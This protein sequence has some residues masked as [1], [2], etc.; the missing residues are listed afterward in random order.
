MNSAFYDSSD[1]N[2]KIGV[3]R[4]SLIAL[5]GHL[6]ENDSF[7]LVLFNTVATVLQPLKLWKDI[8]QAKLKETILRI[9]A[10]GGTDMS[11]G[12][13]CATKLIEEH[14]PKLGAVS[15]ADTE[16]R[17]IFL[18]DM[19][20]NAGETSSN[21]LFGM[22]S[23]NDAK[24]IYATFVGVGLDFNTDLVEH[25]TTNIRGANYLSVQ[26][27]KEFKK[28]MNEDFDYIV[29]SLVYN[30]RVGLA[31]SGFHIDK[32]YGSPEST[33]TDGDLMKI[34]TLFPSAKEKE[35]QTKGG[36]VLIKLR[37]S[38]SSREVKLK[39]SFTDRE[40]VSKTTDVILDLKQQ[41]P[42]YFQDNGIR[43]AV[44]L[45]Q[46]VNL[47]KNLLAGVE[48]NA[49]TG[50]LPAPQ[51]ATSSKG[52]LEVSEQWKQTVL[53]FKEYFES[54]IDAIDD[55]SLEKE[56]KVLEEIHNQKQEPITGDKQAT[57]ESEKSTL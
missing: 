41:N 11:A 3:A 20:P 57:V 50:I 22:A 40:G 14:L 5:L 37:P 29:T 31:G 52:K 30:V 15:K 33:T 48:I 35:D 26:S 53:K 46:Y 27:P 56:V 25:I 21:G 18:T 47:L 39:L 55:S 45:T 9:E 8:N 43:K 13:V 44:L 17:I 10:G 51:S 34:S 19:N 38:D 54:E 12:F 49:T 16:N 36:V 2:T 4:E 24:G 28:Q 6:K 23:R 7:G 42:N 1:R 32:V